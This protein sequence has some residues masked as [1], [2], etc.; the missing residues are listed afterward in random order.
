MTETLL[1]SE[2]ALLSYASALRTPS[3]PCLLCGS[4]H[5][6]EEDVISSDYGLWPLSAKETL[7]LTRVKLE[8]VKS[9]K[10]TAVLEL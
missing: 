6:I 1:K 9:G 5:F 7:G 2:A 8:F 10:S 3:R 4:S